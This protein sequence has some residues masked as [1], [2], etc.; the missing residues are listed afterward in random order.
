MPAPG[1][2][3]TGEDIGRARIFPLLVVKARPDDRR[4]ARERDRDA[5]LVVFR[6]I[7]GEELGLL[8][9]GGALAE[10]DIGRARVLPLLV[11]VERPDEGGV[12][13]DRDRDAEEVARR[14][15]AGEE[16]GL[17]A[18]GGALAEEDIG[19]ARVFLHRRIRTIVEHA[20]DRGVL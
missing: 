9:P 18:P 11:V 20:D 3:L 19:G 2:T 15:I 14:P 16:L 13:R 8:G 10:E 6:P 7:A 5:E 4:I 12:A 17:L 1:G